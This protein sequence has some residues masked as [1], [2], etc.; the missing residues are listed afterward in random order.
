MLSITN[1]QRNANQHYNEISLHSDQN[2]H[3]QKLYKQY[4]LE[5]VWG[6]GKL[7]TPL[8]GM[9]VGTVTMENRKKKSKNRT[10]FD[11]EIQF[12]GIYPEKTMAQKASCTPKLTAALFIVCRTWKQPKCPSTD[13]CMK[14]MWY[15]YVAEILIRH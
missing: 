2:G 12:Q 11:P 14:K 6:K 1:Y 8:V 15:T 9:Y 3:H 13:E 4:M 10:T 5:S 7:P